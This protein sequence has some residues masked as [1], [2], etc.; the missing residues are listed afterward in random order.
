MAEKIQMVRVTTE[1]PPT[2]G[3]Q[4]GNGK[5]TIEEVIPYYYTTALRMATAPK[6]AEPLARGFGITLLA[7]IIVAFIPNTWQQNVAGS[8]TV[9]SF[10]PMLR[11][12]TIDAQIDGRIVRWF[13]N[14]GTIVKA[15]DTIAILR[16]IDTKF[17]AEN[18]VEYQKTI[19][20]NTAREMEL[21][22]VQASNKV[23]QA[24]Q[25][26]RA[27]EAAV[28]QANVDVNTAR[29]Q[30][31]RAVALESQGLIARKDYET[32]LL[33]LQ[34]AMA[35]SAKAYADLQVAIQEVKNAQAELAAKQR[36]ASATIA[37]ADLELGN[38]A[39]RRNLGIVIAPIDG[40]VTRIAQVGPG[41]TVKK[42]D[43]LCI[44]T[45]NASEDIAAEIFVSSLDAAIIDTGRPVRLQFAGF[46]AIQVWG[47]GWPN[48]SVGTFGGKV[49][50]VDAVD[51]GSGRFRVLV[52]P[53]PNDKPWPNRTY[54]RQGTE[55]TGWILLNEVSLAYEAWRQLCGFPPIIPARTGGLDKKKGG[56]DKA[57]KSKDA[58]SKDED[59]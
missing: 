13:V 45:P 24:E 6:T 23:K 56:D 16:D 50:V 29:I 49:A 53:D 2:N 26:Q 55:V 7:I 3:H 25:K 39:T 47:G 15:G 11:P 43:M 42:G 46:P 59:K 35:D 9:T 30:F 20:E 21:E 32:A 48:L 38:V 54:L 8:G 27:V 52:V 31:Q 57:K 4:N 40:Q 51:D 58:V 14:E 36:K 41:Q 34:K 12:Q 5:I 10:A 28:Q 18:F 22:I 44:I 19:R 1:L 17:L 33:R 37:K